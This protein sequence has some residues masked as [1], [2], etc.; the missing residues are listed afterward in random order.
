MTS[1]PNRRLRLSGNNAL[2]ALL[3]CLLLASCG[4]QRRARKQPPVVQEPPKKEIPIP[5]KEPEAAPKPDVY[6]ITYMLPFKTDDIMFDSVGNVTKK[7][8]EQTRIALDYYRGALMALDTVQKAGI[9]LKAYIY[10]TAED[11]NKVHALFDKTDVQ[12]SQLVIGPVYATQLETASRLARKYKVPMVSPF[13]S[14]NSFVERNPYYIVANA[15]LATHCE[16]LYDYIVATHKPSRVLVL[17]NDVENENLYTSYFASH[18]ERMRN[19]VSIVSL[20]DKSELTFDQVEEMLVEGKDNVVIIPSTNET[21]VSNMVRKLAAVTDKYTIYVY[22]MP[23]WRDS[24]SMRVDYL[25]KVNCRITASMWFDKNDPEIQSFSARYTARYGSSPSEYALEGYNQTLFFAS[26]MA[27]KGNNFEKFL[28]EYTM[29][30]AGESFKFE[31][32]K[33]KTANQSEAS[34]TP[35]YDFVENR[36]VQILEYKGG[37]LVK[38]K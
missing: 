8:N 25:D 4:T 31:T 23:Q 16:L 27:A 30:T 14:T 20:T 5:E 10:D 11:T 6:K 9:K 7:L 38:I 12:Q 21:F 36:N 17:H 3:I 32:M 33:R 34:N 35:P 18:E 19:G 15:S 37:R 2:V 13:V 26:F 24:K 29:H 28:P 1:V 22:G